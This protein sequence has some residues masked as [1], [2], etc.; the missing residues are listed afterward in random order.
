MHGWVT[1]ICETSTIR[2]IN[3][4]SITAELCR[5]MGEFLPKHSYT[6]I[7]WNKEFWISAYYGN[8]ML[9]ALFLRFLYY[10]IL[11]FYFFVTASAH[12]KATPKAVHP[13]L[14]LGT[15]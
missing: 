15:Y 13:T 9:L 3:D 7:E 1:S 11:Y 4:A 12:S 10:T 2:S 8:E 5:G 14:F 6:P